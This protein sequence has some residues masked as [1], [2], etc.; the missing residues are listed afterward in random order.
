MNSMARTAQLRLITEQ[1]APR[2]RLGGSSD[3]VRAVFEH[4][5]FMTDRNAARCKLGPSRRGAIAAAL[6][7]YDADSIM[8]A[9]E[10]MA[11][12]PLE[13]CSERMRDAMREL[14]WL[15]AKESRIEQWADDGERLRERAELEAVAARTDASR[16]R[17]APSPEDEAAA[18]AAA[19]E[20]RQR[21][22]DL[23]A[24]LRGGLR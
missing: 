13:G 19:R 17:Q 14:E 18:A 2:A 6:T 11:A 20:Q 3:P 10:G 7:L 12:D 5:V 22:R 16:L 15:L 9:V 8:L 4:W 23:A 21:L 24:T 1:D